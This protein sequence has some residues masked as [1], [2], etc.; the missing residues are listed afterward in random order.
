VFKITKKNG[1]L[2]QVG[3]GLSVIIVPN[4][5]ALEENCFNFPVK[6]K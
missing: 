3:A 2:K 6:I 4:K 5:I 1:N